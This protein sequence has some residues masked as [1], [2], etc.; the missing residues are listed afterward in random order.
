MLLEDNEKKYYWIAQRAGFDDLGGGKQFNKECVK[1]K[2]MLNLVF[3][4]LLTNK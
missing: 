2:L 1:I 4:M 3:Y